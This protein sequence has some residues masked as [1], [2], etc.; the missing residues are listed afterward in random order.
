MV[1]KIKGKLR[2]IREAR[3]FFWMSAR[4]R[5][6]LFF[7]REASRSDPGY[8]V[9]LLI[10]RMQTKMPEFAQNTLFTT[11]LECM[12]VKIFLSQNAPAQH[13]YCRA[14]FRRFLKRISKR[15]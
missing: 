5:R 6:R 13:L 2:R 12:T 15:G 4:L 7:G 11:A 14:Q 3:A 10:L 9:Q 1:F 8:T